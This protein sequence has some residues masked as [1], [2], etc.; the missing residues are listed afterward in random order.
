M[1][2]NQPEDR[3]SSTV[4]PAAAEMTADPAA[5]TGQGGTQNTKDRVQ[6]LYPVT[7][8]H[9]PQIQQEELPDRYVV[10]ETEEDDEIVCCLEAPNI[11][12]Q[13][14]RGLTVNSANA[15]KSPPGTIFLDGA[16]QDAPFLDTE[17]HV[18]NLDHHDGC[19]RSF[20]LSTCEQAYILIRKG[21]H[22]RERDWTV[23]GN[24]P[25]L[26]TVLAIWVLLNHRRINDE[27]PEIR[28]KILPLLRL[29]GLIDVHGLE[30]QE[31]AC[32]SEELHQETSAK[33]SE[34]LEKETALKKEGM[35]AEISFA[36][37]TARALRK[38]DQMVYSPWHFDSFNVIDEIARVEITGKQIAV[39]CRSEAGIYEVE[40]QLTAIH[41]D[42][43][44]MI[45]L[46][47]DE[48]NYSLR[49]VNLFL[50]FNLGRVYAQ[51]NLIDPAATGGENRWGGSAEI[52][53]SP[54]ASGTR[55]SPSEI[56]DSLQRVF[57]K[58]SLV[59]LLST[60]AVSVITASIALLSGWSVA[61]FW[62]NRPDA[63][64]GAFLAACLLLLLIFARQYPRIYG[65]RLP[66]DRDW[67]LLLPAAF[68]GALLGG[69]WIPQGLV[70]D[71]ALQ[72][73][74]LQ[75]ALLALGLPAAAELLFRGLVHGLWTEDLRV[76][77]SK[78]RW[79]VSLPAISSALFYAL[80]TLI[81]FLPR[82]D[83]IS[84]TWPATFLPE[85]LLLRGL[86]LLGAFLFGLACAMARERSESVLVPLLF[87]WFCMATFLAYWML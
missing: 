27:D 82:M 84:Q 52:G 13:V 7:E 22:L 85:G 61:E 38:I 74:A 6:M 16:A 86:G 18:Y 2:G 65:L 58:P 71:N 3:R 39:L 44:G 53:G 77:R 30:M 15:R 12:V 68:I 36:E 25:D 28:R 8:P 51:L 21:L 31:L 4:E 10:K 70:G 56:A 40:K 66:I 43:L 80:A 79:F 14:E 64:T 50:P 1:A 87:H 76:Q 60:A 11:V 23:Y 37:Y 29:E 20:T 9:L 19:V 26:D 59:Q 67:L 75:L 41:G 34:L 33:I 46:Q 45:V 47:K 24:D 35:W 69:S 54:R 42:R 48:Q 32:F 63:F 73:H 78:G 57:N 62:Q 5:D 55:L 83:T 72:L 81:P 17:R 49:Q